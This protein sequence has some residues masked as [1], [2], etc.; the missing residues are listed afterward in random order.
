[1][2]GARVSDGVVWDAAARHLPGPR[3]NVLLSLLESVG[4]NHLGYEGYSRPLTPHLDRLA[5]SSLNFRQA[6]STATHSNYAQMAVLS[7]LFPRRYT[8]LDTYRR[9]D[10]PRVLWH[11]FL[12]TLGYT[13]VTHSS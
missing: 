3:P 13:T 8:G 1:P 7:S 5:E 12:G 9:L 10:Y 2:R 6:R 4:V 11:D